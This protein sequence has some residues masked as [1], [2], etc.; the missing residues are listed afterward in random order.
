MNLASSAALR[1]IPC[2]PH[3]NSLFISAMQP[4]RT[5][6]LGASRLLFAV[7]VIIAAASE[8]R[9]QGFIPVAVDT[10]ADG[11]GLFQ[12]TFR[13]G[14]PDYVWGVFTNTDAYSLSFSCYGAQ[15]VSVPAG[16]QGS[17]TNEF[18]YISYVGSL[19]P[20]YLDGVTF[21]VQSTLTNTMLYDGANL[22]PGGRGLVLGAIF[23]YPQ[24]QFLAGGYT[25]FSYIGP[26][27]VPEPAVPLLLLAGGVVYIGIKRRKHT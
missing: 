24:Q 22:V 26:A 7:L 23:S 1:K 14:M 21:A 17:I 3:T 15:Q 5:L 16:W 9:G 2:A 10:V 19:S 11:T 18:V 13:R 27:P 8:T 6:R 4:L 25:T 12:F 20:A